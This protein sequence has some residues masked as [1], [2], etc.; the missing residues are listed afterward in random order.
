M[1]RNRSAE[2]EAETRQMQGDIGQ[3]REA[4]DSLR[5]DLAT[6]LSE[7]AELERRGAEVATIIPRVTEQD[8]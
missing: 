5:H 6:Q 8:A 3:Q 2:A 4:I 1:R 7:C